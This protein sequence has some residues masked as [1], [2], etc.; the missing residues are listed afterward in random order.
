M[1][2]ES[3]ECLKQ[4]KILYVEDEAETREEL[5]EF[6]KR[7]VGKIFVAPNGK[8]G[9]DLFH[10]H[11]PDIIIADLFMP[12]LG[13]VEM[14]KAIKA[15]GYNPGVIITS[16]MGDVEVILRAVDAG[17]DKYIIKPIDI[18]KLLEELIPL[19]ERLVAGRKECHSINGDFKKKMEDEI[20]K[21]F[22]AFLKTATGKGPKDVSVFLA[23]PTIEIIAYDVFTPFEKSILENIENSAIIKQNRDLFYDTK[24][25]E[26][27]QFI[28]KVIGARVEITKIVTDVDKGSNKIILSIL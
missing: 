11:R 23:D 27:S 10:E 12:E 5:H 20:K 24:A 13:G 25:K 26:V 28:E 14:V 8:A 21:N 4:I 6:L 15:E 1:N 18:K 16:A 7:R 9:L 17:I 19:A 3:S 2:R 22:A